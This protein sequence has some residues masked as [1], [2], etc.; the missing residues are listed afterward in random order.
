[1]AVIYHCFYATLSHSQWIHI[2]NAE[3]CKSGFWSFERRSQNKF[4]FFLER[5]RLYRWRGSWLN[6][7]VEVKVINGDLNFDVDY[8]HF[9]VT[10]YTDKNKNNLFYSKM[11]LLSLDLYLKTRLLS[12]ICQDSQYQIRKYCIQVSW[13]NF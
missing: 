3:T 5:G 12:T 6:F 8:G 9:L 4:N 13:P 11:I 2:Q 7:R 1:M 10:F